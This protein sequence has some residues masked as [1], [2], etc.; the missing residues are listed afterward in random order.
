MC[1][2]TSATTPAALTG[3]NEDRIYPYTGGSR[4][5]QTG[6]MSASEMARL[7]ISLLAI[8]AI[9]GLAL[10]YLKGAMV[11]YFGLAGVALCRPLFAGP[12][13]P[14]FARHWRDCRG[15][16]LWRN[17]DRRRSLVAG[18]RIGQPGGAFCSANQHLGCR[19]TH[20]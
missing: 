4:F 14:C 16:R 13:A 8:A 20:D 18:C 15:H 19:N 9:A 10:I 11:L 3:M 17:T 2:T 5:I 7:G 12:G 6:I 1:L